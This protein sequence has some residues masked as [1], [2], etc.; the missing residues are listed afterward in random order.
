MANVLVERSYLEDIADSIRGKLGV[1]DTYKP[2]EMS[3][4]IDSISGGGITPTGTININSNGTHDVTQYA[5]AAVAVPNS[6]SASDEGKVVNNG[7]L[8]SQ[9][10]GTV[11][12]NGTVDTTLINSLT[13]NVSGG[14]GVDYL[15]QRC[16][17]TLT[18]YHS[19]EVTTIQGQVFNSASALESVVLPNLSNIPGFS[20]FA[21][22][23]HLL[24]ADIGGTFTVL[25]N[26]TFNGCSKLDTLIIR[27]ASACNLGNINAFASTPFASGGTGGTLYVPQ[28]LISTYQGKNNWS[29]ILGYANNSI[30]KIE[31]SI[32]ETAYADGTPIT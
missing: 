16:N 11:T 29:T 18:T 27:N 20:V 26:N 30:Q 1:A 7:G 25:Q 6:Y 24:A 10:S 14:G 15:A 4:A 28:S 22:C 9:S 8:V 32:Y 21:S 31:G 13:V 19:S 2:S 17:N 5:S 3:D 12:E 23:T